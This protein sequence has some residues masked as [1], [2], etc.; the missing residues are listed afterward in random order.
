MKIIVP[1]SILPLLT[2]LFLTALFNGHRSES[3]REAEEVMRRSFVESHQWA[4]EDSALSNRVRVAPG[5]E[6]HP[7]SNNNYDGF[8]RPVRSNDPEVRRA[9]NY[10]NMEDSSI[11][12][13]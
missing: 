6:I 7:Q 9:V 4:D 12:Y 5:E 3:T 8:R 10:L 13:P 1:A 11:P 2:I